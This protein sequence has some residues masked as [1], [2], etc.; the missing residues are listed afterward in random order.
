ML[1]I[2]CVYND[3]DVFGA[4]LR[5][6]LERQTNQA[7]LIAVD[8]RDGRFASAAAALNAGAA[9]ANGDW[10]V[11][12]HQD[13]ELL[14]DDWIAHVEQRLN[15]CPDIGWAGVAGLAASE[16]GAQLDSFSVGVVSGARRSPERSKSRLWT[17][18]CSCIGESLDRTSTNASAAGTR[19]AS[20]PAARR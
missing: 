1:S 4:R 18:W 13:V 9:T 8:N 6:S 14:S 20:T 10:I 7:E 15:A 12:A 11:F 5:R 16:V 3:A 17:R 19:M 2:V